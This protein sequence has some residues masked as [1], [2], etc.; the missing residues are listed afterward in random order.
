[1]LKQLNVA[2]IEPPTDH[3]AGHDL[4]EEPA[5]QHAALNGF[6]PRLCHADITLRDRNTVFCDSSM[7]DDTLELES[8]LLATEQ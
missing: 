1:M 7:N 4:G 5:Q 6:D 2:L 3:C 8:F